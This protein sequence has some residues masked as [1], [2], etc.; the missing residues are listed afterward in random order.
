MPIAII[1]VNVC[2][3]LRSVS[4]EKAARRPRARRR[5]V[6]RANARARVRDARRGSGARLPRDPHEG[7][8]IGRGRPLR[9]SLS[10]PAVDGQPLSRFR[11]PLPSAAAGETHAPDG[12]VS[13]AG[14][15]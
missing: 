3:A 6:H 1:A 8:A 13:P 4:T 10:Q 14:H 7:H 15:G 11:H 12:G 9:S 2:G 5:A